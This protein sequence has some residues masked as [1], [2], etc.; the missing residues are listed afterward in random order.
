MASYTIIFAGLLFVLIPAICVANKKTLVLLDN[1]SLRETHSI[2]FRSLRDKGYELTFKTADD[3]SLSLSKY[4]EFLYSNLVI[5]APSVEEFGGS[6]DVAAITNFIDNGGNVMVAANS[7]I[8]DP[9]RELATECGLEFDDEKTAVI[10]HLNFDVSDEGKHTT[11]VADADYLLDA[12]IIVGKKSA[13]PYIYRGV[14]MVADPENPLVLPLLHASSSAYSYQPDMIIDDYPLAVGTNTLLVAALQ[15]RNNARVVFVGSIDFFSDE[16][17]SSSVQKANGGKKYEKAGNQELA[18]NLADWVFKSRGVLRV[19][20]VK[21]HK[22]GEKQPPQAY[23]IFDMVDYSIEI[24]EFRDGKWQSF[25]GKDVQLEFVRID[26][27]VRTTLSNKNGVFK[28]TFKLPDVYGVYQFR[29]DYNRMGYTHLFS[30]TQV[31]VRPLQHTQYERFIPTAYPYYVSAF[32]MMVGVCVFSLV[33]LHFK[34][35][36]KEK[37]D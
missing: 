36:P 28:T 34:D 33:F 25:N 1:W 22:Q 26:P 21:H 19:G 5:F 12:P 27:F 17:F 35:E 13:S 4:G 20:E 9:L 8:G 16:F 32:S 7:A 23:T 30:T 31:S 24:E 11:I 3:G 18:M 2:F 15:A 14:G 6:V 29:V 37:K 10:D